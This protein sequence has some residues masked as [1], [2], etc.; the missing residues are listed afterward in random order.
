MSS[1]NF[2]TTWAFGAPIDA[3][4]WSDDIRATDALWC[5]GVPVYE[6]FNPSGT[7]FLSCVEHAAHARTD[8]RA[9]KR[10]A[11]MRSVRV[12]P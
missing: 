2:A 12:A 7:V 9:P 5:G 3:C 8:P 6:L 11:S 4:Q 10:I 1:P